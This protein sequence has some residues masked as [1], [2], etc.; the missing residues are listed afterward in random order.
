[1]AKTPKVAIIYYSLYHHI[2]T[3]ADSIKVGVESAGAQAD[4]F[5]VPETLAPEV[6]LKLNAPPARE[7]PIA[8]IETLK[9]Y[10]AYLF[11]I[12]TRF[13]TFPVQWK[14]FWDAT[15]GIWAAGALRGK[16][17][18]VFVATAT[19]GGGQEETVINSLSTLTHHGIVFVPFGYGHPGLNS[20]AEIRGGSAWGAGTFADADGS[21]SV[22]ELEKDIAKTQGHDFVTTITKF[23]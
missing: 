18:G 2:S 14:S 6:L 17:A 19:P 22:S 5:Q 3:L 13:G 9:E 12:P 21:R 7:V 4:L 20:F 23:S 1:M 11:G 8:T 16:F 15:G 10:D